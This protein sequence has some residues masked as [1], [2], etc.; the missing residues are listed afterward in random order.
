VAR[1]F[2]GEIGVSFMTEIRGSSNAKARRELGWQPRWSSWRDG[3]RHA[4][5]EP[6]PPLALAA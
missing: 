1:L 6:A 3:F 2:V 4:L 5:A